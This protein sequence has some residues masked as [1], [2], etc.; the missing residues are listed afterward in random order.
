MSAELK[1][2]SETA[3]AAGDKTP[4][5]VIA[6]IN[7]LS[8]MIDALYG[9]CGELEKT[10][11]KVAEMPEGMERGTAVYEKVCPAMISVRDIIDT[12]EKISST[13]YYKMPS[14]EEMLFNI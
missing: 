11:G 5:F 12:Y 3:V 13:E 14:Y 8:E 9:A 7:Q 1:F 2:Y 10:D 4:K 6:R